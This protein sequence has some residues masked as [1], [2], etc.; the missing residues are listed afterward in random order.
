MYTLK[1]ME[2]YRRLYP[3]ADSNTVVAKLRANLAVPAQQSAFRTALISPATPSTAVTGLQLQVQQTPSA[4]RDLVCCHAVCRYHSKHGPGHIC[5]HESRGE[6]GKGAGAYDE[7]QG[8]RNLP[9]EIC[10]ASP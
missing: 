9:V 6:G 7:R 1:Y 2:A 8:E 4:A 5:E 10:A 3:M